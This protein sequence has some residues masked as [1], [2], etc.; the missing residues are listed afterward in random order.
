[1]RFG[2]E[3]EASP[4]SFS[5]PD[6]HP[7]GYSVDL[8]NALS[9]EMGFSVVL[10]QAPWEKIYAQFQAGELDMLPSIAYTAERDRFIDYSVPHLVLHGAAFV[11]RDGPQLRRAE[12]LRNLR[13]GVQ[14]DSFSQGFLRQRGWDVHPVYIDT[15]R[16]GLQ[17]VADQRCDVVLAVGLVGQKV[18]RELKLTNVVA[19]EVAFPEFN[20]NLHLGV[21]AGDADRLALLNAGLA[22]IKAN[23]VYDPIYEKWIGP[24]QPRAIRFKDIQI[25]LAPGLI[26]VLGLGAA[27]FWQ[28]RVLQQVKAQADALHLSQERLKLV[29]EVGAHS[30]WE[31]DYETQVVR[32]DRAAS[33]ISGYSETELAADPGLYV[34]RVHPDDLH[35]LTEARLRTAQP[36]HDDLAYDYRIKNKQ[37]EW[38]WISTRGKVIARKPDGSALRAVGTNTDIT[39]LKTQEAE[40]AAL[41]A[42]MLD[43]QKL[44]S[45]GVLAGGIAHDFNNLLAVI[46]GNAGLAKLGI[47][48][49]ETDAL[50]SVNHIEQAARR[51]SALCR[52]ML[53]YAGHGP[54]AREQVNLPALITNTSELLRLSISK[55]ASLTF[56]LKPDTPWVDADPSQIQQIVMN[57]V[58]NASE[59][60]GAKPG[61]IHLHA[62]RGP[63]NP[64]ELSDIVYRPERLTGDFA[65][66]EVTDTGCGMSADTRT[67]I[68]EPFFTTKFAGRGLGLAAVLGIVRSHHG[69]F[70]VHSTPGAGSTFRIALPAAP[71]PAVF[72]DAAPAPAPAPAPDTCTVL[73]ADDEPSVLTMV[74]VAL[75][76]RGYDVVPARDGQEA[77]ALF[78][79]QP[80]AFGVVLLDLT[81]PVLD[82]EGALRAIR[83]F[84][85]ATRFLVMSGYSQQETLRRLRETGPVEFLPKP[86]STEELL[87]SVQRVRS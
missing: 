34:S 71:P 31:F 36:G 60:I 75:T 28:R 46:L 3:A 41:Q 19:S 50:H 67:K 42:K 61:S 35:L 72:A 15:L 25:Y 70:I 45:L 32:R 85:P 84:A 24:L 64:A 78:R 69:L 53:A 14:R 82:G 30:L 4:L 56:D 20:F 74:K 77:V 1:M 57:L 2:I 22:R 81:M 79:A 43:A 6:G 40:R 8:V 44:E 63:I 59:A 17:A 83:Q 33:G 27:F 5:G 68:F 47:P 37:G 39:L 62:Y 9:R 23:G 7:V 12:D 86:F 26:I 54:V 73:V 51:A 66:L 10:V 76:R 80:G 38:R 29:L 48:P 18:I 52:Q 49:K 87:A 55:H 16:E 21:R 58:I 65:W 11:R 13:V